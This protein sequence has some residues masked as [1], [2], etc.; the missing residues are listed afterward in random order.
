MKD[1]FLINCDERHSTLG[2]GRSADRKAKNFLVPYN[3]LQWGPDTGLVR[4]SNGVFTFQVMIWA[5]MFGSCF[6]S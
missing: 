1:H 4:Y 5:G 6:S 3:L 2:I